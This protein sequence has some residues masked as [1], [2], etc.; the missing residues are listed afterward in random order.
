MLHNWKHVTLEG[1]ELNLL[2]KKTATLL[3]NL[4]YVPNE[5]VS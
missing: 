4:N 1:V 5:F 3:R 2:K